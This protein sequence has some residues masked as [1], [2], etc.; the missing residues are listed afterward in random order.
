MARLFTTPTPRAAILAGKLV[1]VFSTVIIQVLF[2][3]LMGALIFGGAGVVLGSVAGLIV[4]D[5]V[6]VYEHKLVPLV[7]LDVEQVGLLGGYRWLGRLRLG[8][9]IA[10]SLR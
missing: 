4:T 8:C 3:M 7:G 2:T 5:W 1:S 9:S 6:T 10:V